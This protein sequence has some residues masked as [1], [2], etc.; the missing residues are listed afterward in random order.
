MVSLPFLQQTPEY[1]LN[2]INSSTPPHLR[3]D[4]AFGPEA[5]FPTLG[6]HSEGL[7]PDTLAHVMLLG[8]ESPLNKWT[9]PCFSLER[10]ENVCV[11]GHCQA[12]C[13]AVA[14]PLAPG[15]AV[16]APWGNP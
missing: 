7:P 5:T 16:Q 9:F 8:I 15:P 3:G 13:R 2:R 6:A 10:L 14:W 11:C 12:A 1:F 4:L